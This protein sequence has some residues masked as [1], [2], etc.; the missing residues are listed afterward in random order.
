MNPSLGRIVHYCASKDAPPEVAIVVAV[1]GDL[2]VS[3]TTC[4]ARGV[5]S[6]ASSVSKEGAATGAT[7]AFW[8]WP[9]RDPP[10]RVAPVAPVTPGFFE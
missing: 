8:R 5:W 3:L 6:F 10:A 9:P 4:S 2:T 7:G 1:H